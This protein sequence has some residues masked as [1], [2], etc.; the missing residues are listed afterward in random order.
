MSDVKKLGVLEL[1]D[2][3]S[4]FIRR[5]ETNYLPST[6]DIHVGRNLVRRYGLRTGDEISG[7]VGK[8]PGRG[9]SAPLA[10]ITAINGR[11]PAQLEGRPEFNRLG[12]IHP[13]EQLV[14]ECCP[15]AARRPDLTNRVIDLLCPFGKGQRALIV[16]PAK[17][18][19]TTVLQAVARGIVTNYPESTLLVLLVDE[20]P[21]EVTEMESCGFGEV[22]SSSFDFPAERHVAVAELTLERARRRVE[23][24]EDVVIILDSIT[25][26][27]R[28]YNAVEKGSGRTLSGGLD[29]NS[30]EKP[31]RFLG[32]ARRIDP[33]KGGGSLTVIAT[34]LVDTGSRMDDVIF[35]EFKGTGNSEMVLSRELADRRIFPAIDVKASSTRREELL[36]APDVLTVSRALR[37]RFSDMSA[38]DAMTELLGL[39]QRTESNGELVR[40]ATQ[41]PIS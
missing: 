33:A 36:L 40:K 38:V 22:V 7:D 10:R 11:E 25:R 37:R 18:G 15:Q 34:A 12:A 16:S 2:K 9:K 39:L 29:A 1:I 31:K 19:K 13:D 23:Q 20:R 6:S 21:E 5:P 41:S 26:L 3:G 24:G 17:A 28:A 4:G 30:L 8:A 32:S 27:A 35:E 14:L